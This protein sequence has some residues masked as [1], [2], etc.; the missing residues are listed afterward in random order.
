MCQ[1]EAMRA[2]TVELHNCAGAHVTKVN[3]CCALFAGVVELRQAPVYQPQL[4]L[5]VVDHHLEIAAPG[6]H[7]ACQSPTWI[8]CSLT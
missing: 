1:H 2:A 7:K 5:L 8:Q 4:L 6:G 3:Q